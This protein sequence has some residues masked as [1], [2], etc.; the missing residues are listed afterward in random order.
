MLGLKY[1]LALSFLMSLPNAAN[2]D[3]VADAASAARKELLKNFSKEELATLSDDQIHHIIERLPQA[4]K[5]VR[6]FCIA[7]NSVI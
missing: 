7:N 5:I 2:S 1:F 3:E 4:R 6:H